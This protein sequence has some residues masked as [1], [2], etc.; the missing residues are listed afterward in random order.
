MLIT[1]AC[2]KILTSID[3]LHYKFFITTFNLEMCV[4]ITIFGGTMNETQD[5]L[6]KF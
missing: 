2:I 1:I 6:V 4:I 5:G 3:F